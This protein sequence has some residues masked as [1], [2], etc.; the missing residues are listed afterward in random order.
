MWRSVFLHELLGLDMRNFQA[1]EG[2][3]SYSLTV[4]PTKD[5]ELS[6]VV[7]RP[8]DFMRY[9]LAEPWSDVIGVSGRVRVRL[10]TQGVEHPV[11]IIRIGTGVELALQIQQ[12]IV[13]LTT[14]PG[15]EVLGRA[16]LRV[17][18]N[19]TVI[20]SL[21]IP[22]RR[23]IDVRFDWHTSGQAWF[24]V[25]GRTRGYH[26]GIAPGARVELT[27]ILV[28]NAPPVRRS[29]LPMLHVSRVFVRA[30]RR[31]DPLAQTVD[32]VGELQVP[33]ED[34]LRRCIFRRSAELLALCDRLRALMSLFNAQNT[35][36]GD[37]MSGTL[38]TS[39]S[40]QA[41]EAHELALEA[42]RLFVD[43]VRSRD[44]T[45]ANAFLD[46]FTALLEILHDALP[47]DFDA[48]VAEQLEDSKQLEECRQLGEKVLELNEATLRPL[49]AL[50]DEAAA[51]IQAVAGTS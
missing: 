43:I 38:A 17:G 26:N 15:V 18:A 49:V 47:Q 39:L 24:A 6:M 28:G 50:L 37:E 10:P 29:R 33:D 11:P 2:A 35:S 16:L 14:D 9:E 23:F 25:D 36:P 7:L 45:R 12:P 44:Y 40:P 3:F 27:D 41:V 21:P 19:Q 32:S 42:M 1:V 31:P 20:A 48:L 51:R 5:G 30:L 4:F 34:L 46:T 8:P 13:I 22:H